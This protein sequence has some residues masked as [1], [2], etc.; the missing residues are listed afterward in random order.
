MFFVGSQIIISTAQS[1][2]DQWIQEWTKWNLWKTA[3]KKIE[4]IMVCLKAV[5]LS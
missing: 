5:C 3:F 1:V 4:V 2:Y